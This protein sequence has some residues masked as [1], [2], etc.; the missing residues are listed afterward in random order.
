MIII[1]VVVVIVVL[2]L[3]LAFYCYKKNKNKSSGGN[4]ETNSSSSKKESCCCRKKSSKGKKNRSPSRIEMSM[5]TENALFD[6]EDVAKENQNL[7]DELEKHG[8]SVWVNQRKSPVEQ[9]ISLW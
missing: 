7:K 5:P 6:E 8:K 4:N 1:V 2:A 9:N 3:C